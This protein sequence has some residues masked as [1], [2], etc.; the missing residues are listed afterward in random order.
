MKDIQRNSFVVPLTTYDDSKILVLSQFSGNQK[1]PH[2]CVVRVQ[3]GG[4]GFEGNFYFDNYSRFT[5]SV[6]QMAIENAGS[7]E[8]R[9]DYKEQAIKLEILKLG[10]VLVSGIIEQYGD[11]SQVLRFG[12]KTD[13]TCLAQFGKDLRRVIEWMQLTRPCRPTLYALSVCRNV[14]SSHFIMQTA[15]AYSAT[16]GGVSSKI[17]H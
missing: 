1:D 8:L 11:H 6:E 15:I 3:S 13:Q 16:D 5:A 10:H 17:K 9:E 2:Q 12:F 14:R 7:A 4:F